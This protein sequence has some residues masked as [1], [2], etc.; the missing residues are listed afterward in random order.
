MLLNL[1]SITSCPQQTSTLPV[2][3]EGIVQTQA[4]FY[5]LTVIA[6]KVHC[7]DQMST[8]G[9]SRDVFLLASALSH[10]LQILASQA[11]AAWWSGVVHGAQGV[12]LDHLVQFLHFYVALRIHLPIALQQAP[13]NESPSNYFACSKACESLVQRFLY[14]DRR[15]PAGLFLSEI[16]NLQVFTAAGTLLLLSQMTR[17]I[18]HGNISLDES[19]MMHKVSQVIGIFRERSLNSSPGSRLAK[20]GFDALCSLCDVFQS[21][22]PVDRSQYTFHIP[23]LGKVRIIRKAQCSQA[24]GANDLWSFQIMNELGLVNATEQLLSPSVDDNGLIG[25]SFDGRAHGHDFTFQP[26]PF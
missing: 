1:P 13:G 4:Y 6:N 3:I 18:H 22:N 14:L 2:S 7:L 8:F 9:R 5:H 25:P 15:L 16:I 20:E 24:T 26:R 19:I 11:P 21:E 17:F 10:D 12:D 23:F